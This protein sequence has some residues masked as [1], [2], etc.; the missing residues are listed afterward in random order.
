M[1]NR[2]IHW[3]QTIHFSAILDQGWSLLRD[4]ACVHSILMIICKYVCGPHHLNLAW[5]KEASCHTLS[6]LPK[7][8]LVLKLYFL[9]GAFSRKSKKKT[10]TTTKNTSLHWA[11]IDYFFPEDLFLSLVL[12]RKISKSSQGPVLKHLGL[13]SYTSGPMTPFF[14]CVVCILVFSWYELKIIA[15]S[16]LV[17]DSMPRFLNQ[18]FRGWPFGFSSH[19]SR[20][21]IWRFLKT[22]LYCLNV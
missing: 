22:G 7:S 1:E 9:L 17:I 18:L 3:S 19:L 21:F 6:S 15:L 14:K 20:V 13:S 8:Y 5:Q 12:D 16:I 4:A 2:T 11:Y 10:T